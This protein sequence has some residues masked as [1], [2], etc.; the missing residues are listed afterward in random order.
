VK[1]DHQRPFERILAAID[2]QP[3]AE[4]EGLNTK[5]IQLASSLSQIEGGD[6]DV[7]SAWRKFPEAAGELPDW[8]R[9]MSPEDS[10]EQAAQRT[11]DAVLAKSEMV[12]PTNRIHFVQGRPSV[13]I[14]RAAAE[15][16]A[17]L[18]VMGTVARAGIRGLLIGNTAERVLRQ[19]SCSVLTVK[20]H[21]FVTPITSDDET[22]P[23]P[24]LPQL[25]P[26]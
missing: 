24:W 23:L 14:L 5:I 16:N 2:P 4:G 18:I 3:T 12:V 8:Q 19:V 7:V 1:T 21:N 9:L 17:D 22:E 20:P 11:L 15:I 13:V 26:A 6:L 25:K 10:V